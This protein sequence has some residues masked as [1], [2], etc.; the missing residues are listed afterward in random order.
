MCKYGALQ[1]RKGQKSADFRMA[2]FK[3]SK[4][5][6]ENENDKAVT[7]Q[8]QKKMARNTADCNRGKTLEQPILSISRIRKECWSIQ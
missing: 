3:G 7:S 2:I 5:R 1:L 6:G 8:T 4:I